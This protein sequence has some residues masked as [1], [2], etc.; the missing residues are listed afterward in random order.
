MNAEVAVRAVG[1]HLDDRRRHTTDPGLQGRPVGDEIARERGDGPVDGVG[2]IVG[3]HERGRVVAHDGVDFVD[4]Q[5]VR[6][7]RRYP[8]RA[9]QLFV[10]LDDDEPVRIERGA[11]QLCDRGARVQRQAHE[12]VG[13]GRRGG[14]RHDARCELFR[15]GHEAAEVGGNELDLPAR[16]AQRALRGSEEAAPQPHAGLG[17][18]REVVEQQRAEDLELLASRHA[19]RARV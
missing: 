6:V 15:D 10:H 5:R 4:V 9:R 1:Q 7:L 2:D 16:V 3:Q 8:E 14:R 19:D 12:P 17:E 11:V 13:V 18:H